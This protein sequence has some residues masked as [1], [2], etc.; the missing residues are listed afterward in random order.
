MSYSKPKVETLGEAVLLIQGTK[1]GP[2]FDG[3]PPYGTPCPVPA[4]ELDE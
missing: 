3:P 2:D 1:T 4:Y